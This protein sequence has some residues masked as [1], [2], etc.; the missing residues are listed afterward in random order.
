MDDD[1]ERWTLDQWSD[2]R[3]R[4]AYPPVRLVQAAFSATTFI[5]V[6][7]MDLA[8]NV[9]HSLHSIENL[10]A[11]HRGLLASSKDADQ[12]TALLSIVYWGHY[13]SPGGSHP[14]GYA[15][16]RARAI[17]F[18]RRKSGP[19]DITD[20]LLAMKSAKLLMNDSGAPIVAVCSA[21]A[22]LVKIRN[23]GFSFATK[24]AAFIDPHSAV[25]HDSVINARLRDFSLK[26]PLFSTMVHAP[27]ATLNGK[28]RAYKAWLE[29]C[30]GTAKRLSEGASP[31]RNWNP[32]DIERC[33]FSISRRPRAL[34]KRAD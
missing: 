16:A 8:L 22:E 14:N 27:N 24:V 7:K 20:V 5:H 19:S 13:S 1:P 28:I 29:Y 26:N 6:P 18:G 4:Y 25:I 11:Y 21:L 3:E 17:V 34:L 33:F 15:L 10:E 23:V 32:V 31:R 30:R 2:A 12:L 9:D